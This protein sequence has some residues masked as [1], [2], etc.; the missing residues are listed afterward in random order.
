MG[1]AASR[2]LHLF[3]Y[4]FLWILL[5]RQKPYSS[6][7]YKAAVEAPRWNAFYFT[8]WKPVFIRMEISGIQSE[9]DIRE[10]SSELNGKHGTAVILS[11]VTMELN[12]STIDLL[13]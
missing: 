3:M 11:V 1:L 9:P 10:C 12:F 8:L 13:F 2:K 5:I 7:Y 4:I 6:I